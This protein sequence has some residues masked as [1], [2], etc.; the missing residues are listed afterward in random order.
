LLNPAS[1]L[2]DY[3]RAESDDVEGVEDRD[4]V[5]QLV[6]DRVGRAAERI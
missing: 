2:I 5:R 1:D 6:T 4:G 3:L